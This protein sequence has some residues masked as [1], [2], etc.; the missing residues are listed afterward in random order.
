MP[1]R[2]SKTYLFLRQKAIFLTPLWLIKVKN[3]LVMLTDGHAS[4]FNIDLMR[5]CRD[6]RPPD[7]AHVIQ[8]LD[9]IHSALH[10]THRSGSEKVFN[11][12]EKI[13]RDGFLDI[14]AVWNRFATKESIIKA[15][16]RVGIRE[17]GLNWQDAGRKIWEN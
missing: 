6:K 14:L 3:L 12:N 4:R 7:S 8:L 2:G 11:D 13:E 1:L 16:K 17:Q 9:L 10:H 5:F 15:A